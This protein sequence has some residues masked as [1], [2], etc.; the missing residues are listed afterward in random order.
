MGE[1]ITLVMQG[2]ERLWDMKVIKE[3]ERYRERTCP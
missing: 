3:M 2:P 1:T